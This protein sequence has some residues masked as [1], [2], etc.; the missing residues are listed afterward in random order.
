MPEYDMVIITDYA[1]NMDRIERLV[2]LADR[3]GRDIA[4]KFV[5]IEHLAAKEIETQL[6]TMIEAR[7]KVRGQAERYAM[8]ANERTNQLF[9]VSDPG[10]L[11]VIVEMIRALDD[12]PSLD[13][14]ASERTKL[15]RGVRVRSRI[16]GPTG[17]LYTT[18]QAARQIER[19]FACAHHAGEPV[20]RGIRIRAPHRF[21]QG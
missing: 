17:E 21:A 3:A 9:V 13:A 14:I 18:H 1:S 5:K 8:V 11:E 20:E 10:D 7:G 16:V 12:P 4:I 15:E 19:V 2:A 6:K